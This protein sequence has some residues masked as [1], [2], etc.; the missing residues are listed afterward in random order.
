MSWRERQAKPLGFR[1][2]RPYVLALGRK[3][4]HSDQEEIA[5]GFQVPGVGR[6]GRGLCR[7]GQAKDRRRTEV[8]DSYKSELG[9]AQ[10]HSRRLDG[11]F[12]L[13]HG[14]MTVP[15]FPPAPRT[16]QADSEQIRSR[17][18]ADSEQNSS[19][20]PQDAPNLSRIGV[21]CGQSCEF[22]TSH[23]TSHL[24]ARLDSDERIKGDAALRSVSRQ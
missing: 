4:D 5:V 20:T 19:R 14:R 8:K 6:S 3:K 15:L 1:S 13:T 23:P 10:K 7:S 24:P 11:G 16:S 2:P 12:N 9:Q 22:P 17:F 21:P 18:E